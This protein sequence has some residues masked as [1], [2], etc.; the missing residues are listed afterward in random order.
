MFEFIDLD[1]GRLFV[2]KYAVNAANPPRRYRRGT[3][4]EKE[5]GCQP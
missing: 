2:G 4:V 3:S 5:N 1:E